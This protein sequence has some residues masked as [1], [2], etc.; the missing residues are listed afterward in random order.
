MLKTV[1]WVKRSER[2]LPLEG[3][4]G[5]CELNDGYGYGDG[6]GGGGCGFGNGYG[7]GYG[8]G[9]GNGSGGGDGDGCCLEDEKESLDS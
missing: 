2:V 4:G 1:I 6:S 9:Y 8:Y 5:G 3:T 7:Y